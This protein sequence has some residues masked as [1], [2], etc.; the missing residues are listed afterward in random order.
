MSDSRV[1]SEIEFEKYKK[2]GAYHW[3]Q[4]SY[5]P[6]K[7]NCY[8]KARYKKCVDLV[9][10]C[11]REKQGGGEL[12]VLDFGCG[13]GVLSSL[14]AKQ[15]TEVFGIDSDKAAIYFAEKMH[16]SMGLNTCFSVQSCYETSFE[17]ESFDV[18]V[19][20]DVIE[21]VSEVDRFLGEIHRL[22]KPGGVAVIST[23][24]RVT[25]EKLDDMHVVE[26]FPNEFR[27]V[28]RTS[29]DDP[30]M[31]FSHPMIWTELIRRS[32]KCRV[33]VNLLSYFY[34]PFYKQGNWKLATMQYAVCRK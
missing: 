21:H 9:D 4:N 14:L 34:N 6:L 33:F 29:F 32:R 5:N 8:V 30:K 11:C 1:S 15:G 16:K 25:E 23:P 28:V 26:W 17:S 27:D 31:H 12:K 22:L 2:K 3:E 18:V 10:G 20:S 24:I 19:S 7:M 13:D